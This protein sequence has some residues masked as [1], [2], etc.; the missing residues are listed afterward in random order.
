MARRK[1]QDWEAAWEKEMRAKRI[2]ETKERRAARISNTEARAMFPDFDFVK[3]KFK[4]PKK[5]GSMRSP[6][7]RRLRRKK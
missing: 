7:K 3:G 1:K 4:K 2:Y 6:D 5:K